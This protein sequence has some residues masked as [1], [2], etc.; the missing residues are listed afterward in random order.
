MEQLEPDLWQ[1]SA[2]S[3]EDGVS[4]HAFVLT[5]PT[6]NVLIYG[7]GE[8]NKEELDAIEELGGITVQVLSHRDEASPTL[9]RIRERFG[10]R[11]ACAALEE[12]H[13]CEVASVDLVVGPDRADP[14]LNSLEIFDTP[15]HTDGH[16]CFRYESPHGKTYLFTGDTILPA[17]GKWQTFVVE[18]YGGSFETLLPSLELLRDQQPDLVLSSAFVGE[19]GAEAV[20]PEGWSAAVD[21][22]IERLRQLFG[23]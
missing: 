11:L 21:Y 15:G 8:E 10:S 18:E 23:V 2:C 13:I 16:I 14:V 20:T 6:G 9:D 17:K 3:V 5:L 19:S 7:I 12:A 1:T 22:R 4:T